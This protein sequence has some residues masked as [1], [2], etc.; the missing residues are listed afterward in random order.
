MSAGSTTENGAGRRPAIIA[1]F[2]GFYGD[3][4]SAPREMLEGGPIDFLTGDYLA[5]LTMM[6]LWKSRRK[7]PEAGYATTFLRQMEDMLGEAIDRGVR[8]VADAGGL[9]PQGLAD[10]LRELADKLGISVNVAHI[11]GDDLKDR[12]EEL[13]GAGHPLR[14]LDTGEPLSQLE[15]EPMT[16]NAYLGAWGIV[17]ALDRGADIVV[18]PRV[19][20][21]AVTVGPAAHWHDWRRDDWDALAGAVTAAHV[22]ECGPQ[23]TGGNYPFLE[24]VGDMRSPGFPI[25]EIAADGSSVITKHPSHG[26]A[27]N[28]GTVTAQ[29]LYEIQSPRYLNPDVV[30]R[31]DTIRLTQVDKDRVLIDGVRGEPSPPE[32]KVCINYSGGFRNSM[33]FV[34]TGLDVDRKVEMTRDALFS[35]L[36]GPEA[37]ETMDI[38]LIR[39]G[40]PDPSTNESAFNYLRIT[41]KD[42]DRTKVGRR[43]SSACTELGLGGYPGW[44]TTTPPQPEAEY[45]VYWPTLVPAEVV[46]EVVVAPDGERI[47]IV[48]ERGG[49]AVV[50]EAV[51]PE[52]PP[53]PEGSTEH[54]PI[55]TVVGARSGDKGG[56]A[57]CGVWALSDLGYA[58]IHDFLTVERVAELIPEARG[59]EIERHELPNMRA[60]NFIIKGFLGEGV[61]STTK[62]DAQAKSLGEY[63][64]A[65]LVDVPVALLE[66]RTPVGASATGAVPADRSPVT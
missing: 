17:A 39:S 63:F 66:E 59:L 25:A 16:A 50:V 6:I 43:F 37:F 15:V 1:N 22:I 44:F 28:V 53:A 56:N 19:T 20:D 42:R 5:E 10:R 4:L 61:L 35:K 24:E 27:V 9:N 49:E 36:G 34:L 29:L 8:I 64:R 23:A 57:N 2:S 13:Q 38:Q 51:V 55:G 45:T 54:V 40:M 47:R 58:W 62:M 26:G 46:H 65:K 14:H 52:V 11:E 60:L 30:T 32:T 3:R 18:C 33:T 12:L 48:P 31:F 41:V 7:H 21:A